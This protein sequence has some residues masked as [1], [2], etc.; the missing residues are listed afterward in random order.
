MT[1]RHD[2]R[3]AAATGAT[4]AAPKSEPRMMLA[5]T[6]NEAQVIGAALDIAIKSVG[7][8]NPDLIV[9]FAAQ[10]AKLQAEAQAAFGQP[11]PDQA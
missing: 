9:A 1:N 8:S 7:G 5:M 10:V 4:E 2:R 3:K 11:Q 6:A